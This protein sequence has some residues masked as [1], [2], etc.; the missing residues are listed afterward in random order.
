MQKKNFALFNKPRERKNE[1]GQEQLI[2][3]PTFKTVVQSSLLKK[4]SYVALGIALTSIGGLLLLS[5]YLVSSTILATIGLGIALWGLLFFYIVPSRQIPEDIFEVISLSSA[6]AIQRLIATMGY[7]GK[8]VFYY[9]RS[10]KGLQQGFVFISNNDVP[11][12]PPQDQ[13]AKEQIF[14]ES[15]KGISIMAQS[16]GLVDL[17]EAKLNVNF[18]AIDLAYLQEK[19]PRLLVEDMKLVD[20]IIFEEDACSITVQMMGGSCTRT[21]QELMQDTNLEGHFC[22]PLCSAIALIISKMKGS[23][24]YIK[25]ISSRQNDIF[26]VTR[27]SDINCNK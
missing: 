19:L 16:Q 2:Q 27:F 24:V 12:V 4:K 5:S 22:C 11:Q 20:Q 23:P 6:K 17:L 25:E 21:C 18:A 13:P 8:A 15:P 26:V 7:K 1:D 10:L 3:S 14:Y 9:P